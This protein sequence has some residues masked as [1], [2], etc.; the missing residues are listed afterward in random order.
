MLQ[1]AEVMEKRA[2]NSSSFHAGTAAKVRVEGGNNNPLPQNQQLQRRLGEASAGLRLR[3]PQRS[4]EVGHR[5][6]LGKVSRS[7]S[8]QLKNNRNIPG[9]AGRKANFPFHAKHADAQRSA[10]AKTLRS[11]L[12]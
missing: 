8:N 10:P 2:V 12:E 3:A 9:K 5:H 1:K 6:L 4:A 11:G 7:A